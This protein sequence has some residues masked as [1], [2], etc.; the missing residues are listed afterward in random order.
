VIATGDRVA[1]RYAR[2]RFQPLR[3]DGAALFAVDRGPDGE[4]YAAYRVGREPQVRIGR[5]EGARV[6]E[7]PGLTLTTP[8]AA[9]G[10]SFARISPRGVLWVGLTYEDAA[11]ERRGN[12]VAEVEPASEHVT[13][14]RALPQSARRAH[15]A[16]PPAL[17][18]DDVAFVG[19]DEV[20]L[21]SHEGAVRVRG[22]RVEVFGERRGLA[23]ELRSVAAS[24]G[25]IVFA[26]AR[27]GIGVY[28]GE[29]WTQPRALHRTVNAVRVAAD[30]RLWMATPRGVA[31]FDG[32]RVRRLDA[33]RGLLDDRVS[34][35]E[36][37]GFGRVWALS[38]TGISLIS[39]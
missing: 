35:I 14:H 24:A 33:R 8:G 30:G 21:A 9:A 10:V 2:G 18:A 32:A 37:D 22:R 13:Y 17:T 12:G 36:I 5:V 20:W 11:G 38:R 19:D 26:A 7:L 39:P 28:D 1:W 27:S 31:V 6:V 25:G 4:R 29:R 16:P 3:V 15:G 34:D 23:S